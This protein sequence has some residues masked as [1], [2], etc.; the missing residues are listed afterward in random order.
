VL[1]DVAITTNFGTQFAITGF[2]G[3]NFR[4]VI[5]SDTMF[6]YRGWVFGVKLSDEDIAEIGCLRVVTMATNFGTKIAINWLCVNDRLKR[7]L[8][9][10]EGLRGRPTECKYYRYLH[11]RDV[12]RA[13]T[14]WLSMGYN[15]GCISDML[16][17]SRGGFSGPS[18][19]M[20]TQP[21]SR[22]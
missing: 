13:T 5:A 16:F 15:F 10:G 21:I 6:G 18:Y 1:R 8:M 19:P 9:E 20:K 17:D 11:L 7:L 4:R 14:F 12:A 22:F 2:V 3:Y